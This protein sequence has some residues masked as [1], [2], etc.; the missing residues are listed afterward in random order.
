[1]RDL[2][3]GMARWLVGLPP[4]SRW[5]KWALRSF[6]VAIVILFAGLLLVGPGVLL[7][8]WAPPGFDIESDG[9]TSVFFESHREIAGEVLEITRQARVSILDFWGDPEDSHALEGVR[10]Y[11]GETPAA[12][13][14]LTGNRAGGSAMFGNV[15]VINLSR[16]GEIHSMRDFIDHELAHIYLRKRFGYLNK[17]LAVPMW[18]DEGSALLIQQQA[19]F[20]DRFV[21]EVHGRP[22]LFSV[23]QLR[24]ATQWERMY[25]VDGG[26]LTGLHYGY[27]GWFVDYLRET[28]GIGAL[29]RYLASL[30]LGADPE[31]VFEVVFGRSLAAVEEHW[32][33]LQKEA[34]RVPWE[35]AYAPLPTV[36]RVVVK[37][38]ILFGLLGLALLWAVR[39]V[40]RAVR[41]ASTVLHARDTS[42][43]T[44][45]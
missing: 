38:S 18:L 6:F 4:R 45:I 20:M 9:T 24:Y 10:I 28:Y 33:S 19:P 7:T 23:R 27:V 26:A 41:L 11:L 34:G 5:V 37:W 30:S 17:H 14:R 2:I 29:R 35:T 12:Y 8:P 44:T 13:F 15:I 31:D 1:M 3:L 32:V 42:P 36:P 21:V 16:V 39:Q 40:C 25:S 43:P 22:R